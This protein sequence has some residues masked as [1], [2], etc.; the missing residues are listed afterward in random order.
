MGQKTNPVSL[1]LKKTNKSFNSCWY[2]DIHYHNLLIQEL[3][4]KQYIN[5]V[6][7]QIKY[8]AP[9]VSLS[10]L[11]KKTK[12]ITV[13]FNPA[14]SRHRR[15]ERLQLKFVQAARRMRG[16]SPDRRGEP[17]RLSS[18][19][20]PVSRT[21]GLTVSKIK[22]FESCPSMTHLRW[23][24]DFKD[25]KDF[26]DGTDQQNPAFNGKGVYLRILHLALYS[27]R[28][29]SQY[30]HPG[31][32]PG[33]ET[34]KLSSQPQSPLEGS[35][36]GNETSIKEREGGRVCPSLPKGDKRFFVYQLL[37]SAA[38][39]KGG[40]RRLILGKGCESFRD[41]HRLAWF[42]MRE[43]RLH[44][45]VD[46]EEISGRSQTRQK[47]QL[48][49]RHSQKLANLAK[50]RV[51][52]LKRA[53]DHA[54]QSI[55]S[56]AIQSI[57][58][59]VLAPRSPLSHHDLS[60]RGD[61]PS[62]M[63]DALQLAGRPREAHCHTSVESVTNNVL[64]YSI[65]PRQVNRPYGLFKDRPYGLF[66]DRVCSITQRHLSQAAGKNSAEGSM[67]RAGQRRS[68][69]EYISLL[70]SVIGTGIGSSTRLCFCKSIH[71]EQTAH[72]LSEEI[73]YYLERR[74][75]FRRIKQ[76]LL[77]ELKTHYI[78][79]IRVSCAGRMGGRS[80]KA[81]R[82]RRERFQWGQTSCHVFSSKLSFASR[83]ALTPFGKVGIK[84]WVCYR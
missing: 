77:R 31:L 84:V 70:E 59:R 46:R 47:R 73:A 13:Y 12:A 69:P 82:A 34:K 48:E 74:V 58:S 21:A 15:C 52:V 18:H 80:K 6:F 32:L 19:I 26:T 33:Q 79:G 83:S 14:E 35:P 10:F 20:L 43:E 44:M 25:F 66:K 8:P 38:V 30:Q 56:R 39:R 7:A 36:S 64:P 23:V 60:R 11:P 24:K 51:G 54:I 42:Q 27:L 2:S 62:S 4:T 49:S 68:A 16:P 61:D 76:L 53:S 40:S 28:T 50:P 63:G 71:D 81:Q 65:S 75:P 55:H 37:V 78:E 67:A 57:H 41:L 72:F 17:T 1:R 3:K 9:L 5:K 45:L 29:S 22:S